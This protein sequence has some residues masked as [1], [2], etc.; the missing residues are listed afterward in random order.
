MPTANRRRFVPGAIARFL[1]QDWPSRELIILDDGADAI[2]DIVPD[3]PAIRYIRTARHSSL[4]AKRN[5]ACATARGDIILHWDD[6]D[7]YSPHRIRMQV[8]ALCESGADVC[9]IDRALFLDPG[10]PA[11][12]EYVYPPGDAPWVCGATLCYRRAYWHAHPFADT[13]IGEDTI[14]AAA[15]HRDRLHVLPDITIFVGL[16]HDANTSRRQTRDPRWQTRPIETVR[17]VIGPDWAGYVHASHTSAARQAAQIGWAAAQTID[18]AAPKADAATENRRQGVSVVIPH[19]GQERLPH[20]AA[21]LA[22]LAQC[23]ADHET[24]VVDMSAR[25]TAL[26]V[27][28]RWGAKYIFTRNDGAFE[29]ARALNIGSAVSTGDLLMWMD[30]DLLAPPHFLRTAAD[31]LRH[32]QLDFL[33]PYSKIDYLVEEDSKAVMTGASDPS[34][35]RVAMS[36]APGGMISGGAGLVRESFLRDFGGIPEGFRGW[37]GEDNAWVH[38]AR[39]LGRSAIS[40]NPQQLLRHLYHPTSG[41]HDPA[42]HRKNPHYE[43][44][45]R[46]LNR[47]CAV[48]DGRRFLELF[49]I[50]APGCPWDRDKRIVF[51]VR[52]AAHQTDTLAQAAAAGLSA[53]LAIETVVI[54]ADEEGCWLRKLVDAAPDAVVLFD[55]AS[56]NRLLTNHHFAVLH[57]KAIVVLESDTMLDSLEPLVGRAAALLVAP[58]VDRARFSEHIP[59]FGLPTM[60]APA[61]EVGSNLAQALSIGLAGASISTSFER[62]R[63][64]VAEPRTSGYSVWTY[65]EGDCPDWITACRS[66]IAAHAADA[67]QLDRQTFECLRDIDRDIDLDR[68]HV[69]HRADFIR[70]FL[71]ARYGGLWLDSDCIAMKPLAPLLHQLNGHDFIAHR[72]RQG[73]FPNGFIGAR[74]GSLIAAEF[75]RRICD[76]LRSGQELG[77][78]S[79]GGQP[80]TD[81]LG[82]TE[83][84]WLELPCELIQP[85]CWSRPEVFFAVAARAYHEHSFND[86]AYCYMLSNTEVKKHTAQH[87]ELALMQEGSFFRFL[88]EQSASEQQGESG[89]LR[90]DAARLHAADLQPATPSAYRGAKIAAGQLSFYL[91]SYADLSPSHVLEIASELGRWGMLVRDQRSATYRDD[92]TIRRF[93]LHGIEVEANIGGDRYYSLYDFVTQGKIESPFENRDGHWD[94]IVL[95]DPLNRWPG[96]LGAALIEK[97]LDVA[98]YVLMWDWRE[99]TRRTGT[100]DA[101]NSMQAA[102]QKVARASHLG[103]AEDHDWGAFLLSRRDPRSIQSAR[104]AEQVFERIFRDNAS[105]GDESVSGPGSSLAQT[106]EIRHGLPHLLQSVK[107]RSLLDAPCG[108]FNW[109]KHVEL[110]VEQYIGIDI[111]PELV[112]RNQRTFSG[113]KRRFIRANIIHDDLPRTDVIFCR[114]C[115]VHLSFHDIQHTLQNFKR[116]GATYVLTTSFPKLTANVDIVTGDWRPLNL[117]LKPFNFPMPLRMMVEGCTEAGGRYADKSLALWRLSDVTAGL[118]QCQREI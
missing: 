58:Y 26:Q 67:R 83:V 21:C 109:M 41:A 88:L 108:D 71:L 114:D 75:Y 12:W 3:H 17:T 43:D 116:S 54:E 39:L 65:W 44:N 15:V 29:R 86:A 85:V 73:Y 97:T 11:A 94:L 101:G 19:G 60:G 117:Q 77:W 91:S 45:L 96:G 47:L 2:G 27:A 100:P 92:K 46:L 95:S 115:L 6:D 40:A 69:A 7:W 33:I 24:I 49:P 18:D 51:V 87:P 106:G 70:A 62:G 80:L 36:L 35:C 113:N 78:I 81:L 16:I 105:I 112:A 56:S 1:A 23:G 64:A 72:D 55:S 37:G 82:K 84:P 66:T 98:D 30:N 102:W 107:A 68:L 50:S 8:E 76:I 42:V 111:V 61:I 57:N 25:P 5:A 103:V 89:E 99:A 28:R 104:A 14:F 59:V 118:E 13:T 32:R 20:L 31:E 10:A 4:G 38:K 53:L 63:S 79:L 9:G 74:K 90:Q 52:Q 110:G 34:R 48:T 22:N 93:E